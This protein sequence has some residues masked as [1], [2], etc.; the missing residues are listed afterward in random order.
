MTPDMEKLVVVD[1][2]TRKTQEESM[3]GA[4]EVGITRILDALRVHTEKKDINPAP[5]ILSTLIK[6]LYNELVVV[7]LEDP[8]DTE[9]FLTKI[10][11]ESVMLAAE[12]AR[13]TQEE[14]DLSMKQ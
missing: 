11:T 9:E 3:S 1:E 4:I 14:A 7:L 12:D 2:A 8:D 6:V 10:V 13:E 5:V